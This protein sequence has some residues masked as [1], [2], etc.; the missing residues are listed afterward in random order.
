MRVDAR[1]AWPRWGARRAIW[2]PPRVRVAPDE[3]EAGGGRARRDA[4]AQDR[5]ARRAAWQSSRLD[6]SQR[7]ERD[8]SCGTYAPEHRARRA[9]VDDFGRGAYARRRTRRW[10]SRCIA[11][12]DVEGPGPSG[13]RAVYAAA[14]RTGRAERPY[15]VRSSAGSSPN[16]GAERA[17]GP[18]QQ[19]SDPRPHSLTARASLHARAGG[20]ASFL[21]HA[22]RRPHPAAP[23]AHR[24]PATS[25]G[26]GSRATASCCWRPPRPR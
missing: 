17:R 11:I 4:S 26:A 18:E 14:R 2:R 5:R 3:R 13:S 15:G 8:V 1:P 6:G 7:R 22:T 10:R 24:G 21:H 19:R 16:R 23:T 25:R 20:A 12:C 9:T